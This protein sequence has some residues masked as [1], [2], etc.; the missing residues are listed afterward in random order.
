MCSISILHEKLMLIPITPFEEALFEASTNYLKDTDDKLSFN[1][2]AY[3][4]RELSRIIL[5]RLAPAEEIKKCPWYKPYYDPAKKEIITRAQRIQYAIQYGLKNYFLEKHLGITKKI[6][7]RDISF[8]L[9]QIDILNSYTHINENTFDIDFMQHKKQTD[10]VI[11][12]FINFVD[13]ILVTKESIQSK[14]FTHIEVEL[15]NACYNELRDDIDWLATHTRVEE[16]SINNMRITKID[17]QYIYAEASVSVSIKQ[18]YGSDGDV[19]RDDGL[20]LNKSFDVDFAFIQEIALLPK[21]N[22]IRT[23]MDYDDTDL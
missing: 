18:Q 11:F 7:D 20:I 5:H 21:Y 15:E 14:I 13:H 22:I 6:I 3:S 16:Y 4:M 23:N 12:A 1:S 17:S 19:T 8:L 2:F 9:K 10:E